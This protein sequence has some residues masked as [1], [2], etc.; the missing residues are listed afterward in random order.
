MGEI[1]F[2]L[3]TTI[4]STHSNCTAVSNTSILST[5]IFNRATEGVRGGHV[6]PVDHGAMSTTCNGPVKNGTHVERR[7]AC[8]GRTNPN[9]DAGI[10]S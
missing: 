3:A 4:V 5:V 2:L 6:G 9:V 10:Q 1:N 8:T 7:R